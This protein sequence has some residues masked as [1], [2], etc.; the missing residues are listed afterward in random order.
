MLLLTLAIGL[1]AFLLL[2]WYLVQH[3]VVM[4]RME[5]ELEALR[6]TMLRHVW[7]TQNLLVENQNFVIEGYS[8]TESQHYE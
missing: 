4:D 7:K 2:F 8:L 1:L 5:A 3:R 6:K